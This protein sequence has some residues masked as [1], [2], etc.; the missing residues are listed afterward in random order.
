MMEELLADCT[1]MPA[2]VKHRAAYHVVVPSLQPG[3]RT[4]HGAGYRPSEADYHAL[5]CRR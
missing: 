4:E 3:L 2:Q 5:C 1:S